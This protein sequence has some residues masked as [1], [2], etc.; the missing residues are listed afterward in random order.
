MTTTEGNMII[1]DFMGVGKTIEGPILYFRPHTE[2]NWVLPKDLK[3]H[4]SWD[5]LIPVAEKFS[6][7]SWKLNIPTNEIHICMNQLDAQLTYYRIDL[8]WSQLIDSIKWYN[9]KKVGR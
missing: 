6:T 9:Q 7:L 5:W 2:N 1:A 4:L 3:Y 8:F